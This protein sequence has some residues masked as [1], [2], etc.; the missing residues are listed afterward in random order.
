MTRAFATL[1]AFAIAAPAFAADEK[2]E[3]EK[4]VGTWKLTKTKSLPEG[5]SA[6]VVYLK[7]GSATATIEIKGMKIELKGKWKIDGDKLIITTKEGDKEKV[8]TDTILK[9]SADELV[10]KNKD[11]EEDT[12]TKVK[13]EKK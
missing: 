11:G 3:S 5:A 12:F 10:T 1:I 8:D 13:E 2:F 6:T 9:L 4:L 7:D